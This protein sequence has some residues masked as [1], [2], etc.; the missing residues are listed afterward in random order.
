MTR[1]RRL[2]ALGLVL[3]VGCA[4]AEPPPFAEVLEVSGTPYEQGLA[5]GERFA[6]KIRSLRTRLL[7]TSL[8]PMLGRERPGIAE[9]L[10][11]YQDPAYDEGFGEALLSESAASLEPFIPEPYLEE[12]HGIADG[13]GLPYEDILVL[14]TFFDTTLGVLAIKNYLNGLAA[15]TLV[16]FGIEGGL[17]A[18]GTDNDGDGDTDEAGEGVVDP[19]EASGH[20]LLT[21]VPTTARLRFVLE[22]PDGVDPATLRV[23]VDGRVYTPEDAALST[24]VEGERL[25]AVLAPEGGLP[26]ARAV[27]ILLQ[28]GDAALVTDPPPAHAHF[29]REQWIV[30]GT[31][32]LEAWPREVENRARLDDRFPPPSIAFAASGAATPDG[33]PVVGQHFALLDAGVLHEHALLLVHRP[34]TGLDHVT[35]GWTGL[36]WG[37]SGMNEDGLVWLANI[38]DS[39]D[40][41]FVD[42]VRKELIAAR[43]LL[44]GTPIG[45]MG[46]EV[47]SG[48]ATVDE[49]EARLGELKATGGWNVLLADAEGRKEAVEMD[50]DILGSPDHGRR[51]YDPATLDEWDRPVASTSPD[52]LRIASHFAENRDDIDTSV[53]GLHIGPQRTWSRSW[54]RSLRSFYL[55]GDALEAA[56]GELD[57]TRAV[58]ILRT[59]ELVD[60]RD[61][62]NAVVFEPARR[63]VHW[64]MGEVPA[65]DAD[66]VP[67]DLEVRP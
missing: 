14:N 24:T 54:H 29:M 7:T 11:E 51:V 59:P 55:L 22:D 62:M 40:N 27:T 17:A 32:G 38:S 9:V 33:A 15:P 35:L 18:D 63:R 13:A 47:L 52:D 42:R 20:A 61:S 48:C 45:F 67:F 37:T 3:L 65:T 53:L 34:D 21:R 28:A 39:L 16:S 4:P 58:G 1:T 49:A 23:D 56:H 2:P 41:P 25:T 64:A 46:R 66:F 19:Y 43:L 57:A 12:M 26:P 36:V 8:L 44:E 10:V 6:S 60:R 31:E 30:V 5:H 50:S